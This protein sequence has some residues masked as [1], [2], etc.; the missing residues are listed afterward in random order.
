[1]VGINKQLGLGHLL[2]KKCFLCISLLWF[3]LGTV[4]GD[5]IW[6]VLHQKDCQ[7][8]SPGL[9]TDEQLKHEQIN[10]PNNVKHKVVVHILGFV[11]YFCFE[12]LFG[13]GIICLLCFFRRLVDQ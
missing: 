5:Q 8:K 11:L 3:P 13:F 2:Q 7:P 10:L 12:C 6:H 4:R 9:E 1:M